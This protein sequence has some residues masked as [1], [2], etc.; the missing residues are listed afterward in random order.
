MVWF[1]HCQDNMKVESWKSYS[2]P[3]PSLSLEPTPCCS[4]RKEH[5]RQDLKNKQ[6]NKRH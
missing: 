6:T 4:T 5:S 3:F 2:G 1:S